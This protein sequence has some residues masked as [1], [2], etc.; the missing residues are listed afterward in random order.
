MTLSMYSFP[1]RKMSAIF[2]KQLFW[3]TCCMTTLL[4]CYNDLYKVIWYVVLTMHKLKLWLGYLKELKFSVLFSDSCIKPSLNKKKISC[5]AIWEWRASKS[6]VSS[7][8]FLTWHEFMSQIFHSHFFGKLS[9]R[10]LII[11]YPAALILT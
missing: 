5:F 3:K 8:S 2:G 4:S 9:L 11:H 7:N 6:V 10:A 1:E